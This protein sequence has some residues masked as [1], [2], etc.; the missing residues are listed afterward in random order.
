MRTRYVVGPHYS[1][2]SVRSQL[3][4][5]EF[6][7]EQPVLPITVG[8]FYTLNGTEILTQKV[9]G[10]NESPNQTV[11]DRAPVQNH[12]LGRSLVTSVTTDLAY[13]FGLM[14]S[15]FT[16]VQRH[17]KMHKHIETYEVFLLRVL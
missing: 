10:R 3:I 9:R 6:P 13:S 5:I 16:S 7:S 2:S 12:A 14:V 8:Q 17:Y 11:P 1:Q 4:Q 15:W